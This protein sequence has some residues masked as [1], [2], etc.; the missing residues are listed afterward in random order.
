MFKKK[1]IKIT[2]DQ[3]EEFILFLDDLQYDFEDKFLESILLS[4]I[5]QRFK[6]ITQYTTRQDEFDLSEPL[7]P[8][9]YKCTRKTWESKFLDRCKE[10]AI[11]SWE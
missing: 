11:S 5:L 8:I 7:W 1:N 2:H 4:Y 6:H 3:R 10:I 9:C